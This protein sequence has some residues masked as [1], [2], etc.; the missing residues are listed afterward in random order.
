MTTANIFAPVIENQVND[1]DP[2][3]FL[4]Y[5]FSSLDNGTFVHHLG[6]F[7]NASHVFIGPITEPLNL[8]VE[9]SQGAVLYRVFS[10]EEN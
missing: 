10:G 2:V 5:L 8:R 3:S 4:I 1:C 9:I 6:V 7:R